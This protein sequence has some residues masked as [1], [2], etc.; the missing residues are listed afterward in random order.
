MYKLTN[1]VVVNNSH[2]KC[3]KRMNEQLLK[4]SA[5]ESKFYF[6][7]FEPPSTPP[8]TPQFLPLPPP[9]TSEG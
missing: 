5:P 1:S 9:C 4:V 6:Q 8:P 3:L 7:N 2:K